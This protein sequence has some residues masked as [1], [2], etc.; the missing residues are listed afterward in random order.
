MQ[1]SDGNYYIQKTGQL[2]PHSISIP[3]KVERRLG[4]AADFYKK[5]L[6]CRNQGFG[7]GALSYFRR[8]IEDKTTDLIDTL[9]DLAEARGIDQATVNEIRAAKSQRTYDQRLKAA[10]PAIPESLRPGG[11]N[12]LATLHTLLSGGIHGRTEEECLQTADDVREVFDHII[13]TLREEVEA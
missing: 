13:S 9:A 3:A 7:V 2:P 11:S 10:A 4:S 8:V 5:G 6:I 1:H 12:P